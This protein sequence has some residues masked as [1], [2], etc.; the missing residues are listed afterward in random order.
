MSGL[1]PLRSKA[2]SEVL[3]GHVLVR[4]TSTECGTNQSCRHFLLCIH[5]FLIHIQI[6]F[7]LLLR[8]DATTI[9]RFDCITLLQKHVVS[10]GITI[11][12]YQVIK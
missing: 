9:C 7:R 1:W 3:T 10:S 5:I 11:Q 6:T 12:V 4:F 8:D 2:K